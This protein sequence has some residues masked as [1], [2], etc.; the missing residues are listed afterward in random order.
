MTSVMMSAVGLGMVSSS[1]F[2]RRTMASK[3]WSAVAGHRR[4][5]KHLLAQRRSRTSRLA[6]MQ[7]STS[8]VDASTQAETQK[9]YSVLLALVA[10]LL[11]KF[12]KQQLHNFLTAKPE[13][14]SIPFLSW[15]A[16]QE[17][18]AVGEQKMVLAGICEELVRLREQLESDRM[19]ELYAAT[20]VSLTEADP[21]AAALAL[22]AKP[23][24]YAAK[25]AQ[26]VTGSPVVTDGFDPVYDILL[27]VAPP[28]A[29]TPEGVAKGH[30]QARELAVDLRA[31]RKRSVQSM[32]GRAQL[33]P[34]QADKLLAGSNASRILDMLLTLPSSA[35]RLACLPDCFQPPDDDA[36]AAAAA[37]AGG[38]DADGESD[39][40]GRSPAAMAAPSLESDAEE[41]VWCT[42]SQLL[43]ELEARLQRLEGRG[44]RPAPV[45][46]A[47]PQLLAAPGVHSL[48]GE[49]LLGELRLLREEV[50]RRWLDSLEA[51]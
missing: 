49:A 33:T 40:D 35:D 37:A 12:D 36:A 22:A 9:R 11:S 13:A 47:G 34:E 26:R 17:A 10:H 48:T 16:D 29:L 44:P 6:Q 3:Q 50:R 38:A 31:R 42:P 1:H 51:K 20:L 28:A 24:Q 30:E 39:G 15:L 46:E 8:V 18:N 21:G 43:V 45:G 32:I 25:L 27:K 19:G 23:E 41:L 14:V 2:V 7:D 4:H 5:C